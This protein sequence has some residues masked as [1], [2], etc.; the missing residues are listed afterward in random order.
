MG[1]AR[2]RG[3]WFVGER[4]EQ[5]R[6]VGTAQAGAWVPAWCGVEAV[7]VALCDVVETTARGIHAVERWIGKPE[8]PASLLVDQRGQ[9]SP[10][11]CDGTRAAEDRVL[12]LHTD[13]VAARRA[14]ISRD[15]R[16]A[17]FATL[18]RVR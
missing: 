7:V 9:A 2:G 11:W 6:S 5:L 10:E 12:S 4:S 1:S 3:G 17:P 14:G 8:R 13:R 16:Y 18:D 15:V